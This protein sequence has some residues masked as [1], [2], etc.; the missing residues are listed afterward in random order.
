MKIVNKIFS[1]LLCAAAFAG[2]TSCEGFLKEESYGSTTDVFE[3]ETGIKALYYLSYQK[4]CN[5]YGGEW[6]PR[7]TE[8]GTDL[9]L[10]GSG[11][12]NI[13]LAD[14]RGLDAQNGDVGSLWNHC[15]KAL[16]NI[17][18]FLE[19]IDDTPFRDESEKARITDEIKVMRAMFLWVITETWGD[20]FLPMST[21]K[22]EGLQARRSTKEEFYTEIISLLEN[23]INNGNIKNK[24]NPVE[25]HGLIDMPSVK[26]FLARIYLYHEDF[27]KAAKMAGEVI[28]SPV[29]GY[30]LSDSLKDLWADDKTNDEFIWTTNFSD[31]KSYSSGSSYWSWYAMDVDKVAGLKTELGWYIKASQKA[32]P[33][34]YYI[35]LFDQEADLRWRELHQTAFLYNDTKDVFNYKDNQKRVHIDTAL[36]LYPGI[37]TQKMKD[38]AKTRYLLNDFN[39]LYDGNDLPKNRERFIGMTKFYDH[40]RPGDGSTFANRSYPV[41]RLGELYLIRAEANIRKA[42]PDLKAAAEDIMA[43]R[44]RSIRKDGTEAQNLAWRNAMTVT[45]SDM[46]INFILDERAR[47]LG[48]EWQRWL[49][50]NRLG[51]LVERVKLYNGDAKNNIDEHHRLRPIPQVQFDGMPDWTTLGQN[52]GY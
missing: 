33:T 22:E 37:A 16:A 26:A 25:D 5:L 47:E 39:D 27:D 42:N 8:Q 28:D 36:Y 17:N 46:N 49:D 31:D 34:K 20:S 30:Q 41:I 7:M 2:A 1:V 40:T 12:P 3:E 4:L 48:G 29:Y 18:M 44:E 35:S 10:R 50:L 32:V 9:F 21:D 13:G 38:Y 24:R 23:A 45:E 14:Y 15:Y 19:Q 43:L 11:Q 6:W 52:P 51:L